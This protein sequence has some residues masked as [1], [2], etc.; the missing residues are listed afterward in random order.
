MSSPTDQLPALPAERWWGEHLRETRWSS[1]SPGC[2]PT[3]CS[4]D[5]GVPRG[6]GRPVMLMP[7]FGGGD[8]TLL[9]LAAWLR[10][11]GYRPHTCGFVANLGCS[12]RAV[13]RV[14]RRLELLYDRHGR[15]VALI[16]HS[17]GG[18]YVRA[19]APPPAG[20]RLARDLD[21]GRAAPDARDQLSR[22]RPRPAPP[23]GVALRSRRARSPRLP[24][25]VLR[26][27]R[28]PRD[29]AGTVP[30]RP[31]APHQHLLARAT[32]SSA[33]RPRSSRTATASR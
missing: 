16:G 13:D 23:A 12:D 8:Q 24:D 32:A 25:R 7:G 4:T 17:R 6:D 27:P 26:L 21:R 10:R 2:S 15:R 18:H 3:R 5:A 29:F 20:A 9:V 33:G 31:R 11:I 30:G 22:R 19:L 28:S 14:E 1:S